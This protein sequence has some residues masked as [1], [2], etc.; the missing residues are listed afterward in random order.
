M[1]GY[2]DVEQVRQ[3]LGEG[4]QLVEVLPKEE[5]EFQ[6]IEGARHIW[7]REVTKKAP[8]ELSKDRPVIVY[9]NNEV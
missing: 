9:C 2:V 6:H 4:A 1:P 7:I 5:Y 8:N 3:M